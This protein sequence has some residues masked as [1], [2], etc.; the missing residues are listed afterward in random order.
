MK[1]SN[2][3]IWDRTSDLPMWHSTLTIVLPRSPGDILT[4]VNVNINLQL[5]HTLAVLLIP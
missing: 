1:N 5:T 4:K 3:A 2:D